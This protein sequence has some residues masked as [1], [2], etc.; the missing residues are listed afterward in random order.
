MYYT[1]A[2]TINIEGIPDGYFPIG[3][4]A[5]LRQIALDNQN[6]QNTPIEIYEL[7]T[8]PDFVAEGI[9]QEMISLGLNAL[10]HGDKELEISTAVMT[11]TVK[12]ILESGQETSQT[13]KRLAKQTLADR[14]LPSVIDAMPLIVSGSQVINRTLQA[15]DVTSKKTTELFFYRQTDDFICNDNGYFVS[16]QWLRKPDNAKRIGR[17]KSQP[18]TSKW[19]KPTNG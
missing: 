4:E 6:G 5:T 10:I 9:S 2:L 3:D 1:H 14:K 13:F 12:D 15:Y 7:N 17:V 8:Q 18:S 16:Q 11:K 19:S